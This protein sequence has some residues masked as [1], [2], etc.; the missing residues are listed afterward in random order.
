MPVTNEPAIAR[1]RAG[2]VIMAKQVRID[3]V[4]GAGGTIA[5]AVHFQRITKAHQGRTTLPIPISS[6]GSDHIG[7]DAGTVVHM[8]I[9]DGYHWSPAHDFKQTLDP[10]LFA[11]MRKYVH[12][13]AHVAR[14]SNA[15]STMLGSLTKRPLGNLINAVPEVVASIILDGLPVHEAMAIHGPSVTASRM[16]AE[17]IDG[18]VAE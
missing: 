5:V 16:K 13:L 3:M 11:V 9:E 12:S 15:I 14:A 8:V 17:R 1:Y 4:P 18:E 6:H 2:V 7:T 10:A